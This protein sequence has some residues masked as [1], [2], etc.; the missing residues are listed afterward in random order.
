MQIQKEEEASDPDPPPRPTSPESAA[1]AL[2]PVSWRTQSKRMEGGSANRN[3]GSDMDASLASI[4]E[5]GSERGSDMDASLA[6]VLES[7][8]ESGSERGN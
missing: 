1:I 4:L 6:S 7:S 8:S 5:S 2:S 3:G